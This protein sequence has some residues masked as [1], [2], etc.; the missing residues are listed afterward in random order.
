VWKEERDAEKIYICVLRPAYL[1]VE[2]GGEREKHFKERRARE[3]K[4]RGKSVAAG[5]C[6]GRARA[7]NKCVG[8]GF[9]APHNDL[10]HHT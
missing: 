5:D 6:Q 1:G 9:R 4:S 10:S 7:T 2:L 3:Q 8:S